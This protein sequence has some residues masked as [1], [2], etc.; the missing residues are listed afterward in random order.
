MK[1]YTIQAKDVKYLI[2]FNETSSFR[3]NKG[4]PPTLAVL[5]V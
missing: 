4:F 2:L 3:P 5:Q 1:L